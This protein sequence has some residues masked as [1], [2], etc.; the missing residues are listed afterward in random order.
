MSTRSGGMSL[1][2]EKLDQDSQTRSRLQERD[3][4]LRAAP[5]LAIDQVDALVLEVAQMRTDVR[6]AE[7]QVMQPRAAA[8]QKAGNRAVD[9]RGLQQFDE[10]IAGFDH[11][12]FELTVG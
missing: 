12:H 2:L 11:R 7:A 9:V 8:L 3:L 1:G 10:R 4:A 5:R 6:R